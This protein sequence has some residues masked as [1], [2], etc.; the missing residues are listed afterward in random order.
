MKRRPAA[1]CFLLLAVPLGAGGA[2]PRIGQRGLEGHWEGAIVSV[3]AELEIEVAV[4][5]KRTYKGDLGGE[6]YFPMTGPKPSAIEDLSLQDAHLS[7]QV[8]DDDLVVTSFQGTV[9]D[10][11]T[12]AGTMTERGK[13]LPFSLRRRTGP[14]PPTRAGIGALTAGTELPAVFDRD[15]GRRRILL[16]LSPA[17]FSSRMT[18]SLI[19]RYVLDA[20]PDPSLRLYVFWEVPPNVERAE[21][22]RVIRQ[23]GAL[24][25]DV[26][27]THFWSADRTLRKSLQPVLARYGDKPITNPCLLFSGEKKWGLTAPLPDEIRV[28]PQAGSKG[29][30]LRDRLNAVNFALDVALQPSAR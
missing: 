29:L 1:I 3:P 21:V 10:G 2:E 17:L 4:D 6:V 13:T 30:N 22:E 24:A 18:L 26:R 16:I 5:L 9:R 8:H 7:F 20:N 27:A 25:A 28:G 12:I 14:P 11:A 19:R 23:V 15:F